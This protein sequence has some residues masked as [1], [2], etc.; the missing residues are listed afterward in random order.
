MMFKPGARIAKERTEHRIVLNFM[1]IGVAATGRIGGGYAVGGGADGDPAGR[2]VCVV[3]SP[4]QPLGR[5][6]LCLASHT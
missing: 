3:W 5:A 6:V 2:A 1:N 4:P